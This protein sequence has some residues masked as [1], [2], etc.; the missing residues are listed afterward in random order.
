MSLSSHHKILAGF[1]L[2]M[3]AAAL[4]AGA[5]LAWLYHLDRQLGTLSDVTTGAEVLRVMTPEVRRGYAVVLAVGAAG[6]LVSCLCIWWVWSTLGRVLRNVGRTLQASSSQ[7]L[8]SAGALSNDSRELADNATRAAGAITSTGAAIEQLGDLTR[9][10]TD[11]AG[12][13][14][15]LTGEAR[16]AAGAGSG[17][18]QALTATMRLMEER[19]AEVARILGTIDEIA[20]Q[21]NLLALNA[22]VEAAR[23]GEAGV[24][25]SVVAEEV[26][27]LARRSAEAA[28]ETADRIQTA[29]DTTREGVASANRAAERLQHIV[30]CNQR[31]DELAAR[32][33]TDS[34]EQ[35]AG[36]EAL[37]ASATELDRLTRQN[38]VTAQGAA[39]SSGTLR[40][41]ADHLGK[42][43]LTLRELVEGAAV[44]ATQE[45]NAARM[46]AASDGV[47][48][49]KTWLS[50]RRSSN[51]APCAAPTS[52]LASPVTNGGGR[53]ALSRVPA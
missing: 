27:S 25:F 44:G 16:Q 51:N 43:V 22:A 18:M 1:A 28:R 35:R 30:S 45:P 39:E 9:R 47:G 41:E 15:Q 42:A 5:A 20:F 8:V 21:T 46:A 36:L 50:S 7:V 38:A 4:L 40:D 52:Q 29:T 37:R 19:S 14:R 48:R 33:E 49:P 23:A 13:L 26:R 12:A 24:G 10:N 3:A 6:T 11:N 31:L 34:G 32:M 2:V 17:E 53:P